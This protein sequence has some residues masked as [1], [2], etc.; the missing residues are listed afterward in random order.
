[1]IMYEVSMYKTT[2]H[3]SVSDEMVAA[4]KAMAQAE[5]RTVT[6]M[7]RILLKQAIEARR[8]AKEPPA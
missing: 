2:L 5:E 6:G 4:M 3:V 7:A 8:V 1:M